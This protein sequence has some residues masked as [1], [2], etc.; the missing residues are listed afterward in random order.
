MR[1]TRIAAMTLFILV[2]VGSSAAVVHHGTAQI[3]DS[4]SIMTIKGTVSEVFWGNPHAYIKIAV[5]NGSKADEWVAE[6]GSTFNLERIGWARDRA[7][8]G[9]P[10][11]M[12]GWRGRPAKNPYLGATVDPSSG[13]P[14]L[15]R[16]N[17]ADFADGSRFTINAP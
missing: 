16:L 11:T 13:L 4:Q 14:R 9:E 5:K 12:T 15:L 6:L 2:F 17:E 8:V 7:K 10:I 3:Y 1:I